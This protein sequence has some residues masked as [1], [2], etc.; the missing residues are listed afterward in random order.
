MADVDDKEY[1]IN[2]DSMG[3]GIAE[4]I[5]HSDEENSKAKDLVQRRNSI[6]RKS[7]HPS[8][9]MKIDTKI[10]TNTASK[11]DS[12]S[13]TPD[14]PNAMTLQKKKT[15]IESKVRK[16]D[17]E[18]KDVGKN[19]R[20]NSSDYIGSSSDASSKQAVQQ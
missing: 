3:K 15:F 4:I 2:S 11:G 8:N 16:L 9:L 19:D 18:I 6:E 7:K 12:T 5:N 20:E 10:A 17:F 13:S 1:E 14:F